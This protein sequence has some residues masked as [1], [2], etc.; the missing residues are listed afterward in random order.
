MQR[1]LAHLLLFP[2]ITT[3]TTELRVPPSA[4]CLASVVQKAQEEG[5]KRVVL[6]RGL[7]RLKETLRLGSGIEVVGEGAVVTGGVPV[8][9]WRQVAGKAWLYMTEAPAGVTGISQLFDSGERVGVARSATMQYTTYVPPGPTF[10]TIQVSAGQ[11]L[12]NYSNPTAMRV[13]KYEYWTASYSQVKS[14]E[15]TT[16]V[17][18]RNASISYYG[19]YASGRRYYLE[20]AFEYLHASSGSFYHDE[21]AG[22]LYYAPADPTRRI[23]TWV[24]NLTELVRVDKQANVTMRGV[25]LQHSRVNWGPCLQSDCTSQSASFS[26]AAAVHVLNSSGVAFVNVTVKHTGDTGVW[27]DV[28][29]RDCSFVAGTVTDVGGSGVRIGP[30]THGVSSQLAQRITVSD[31]TITHGS[32]IYRMGCGVLLQAA[33]DVKVVH[34]E[35]AY[36]RYT[37]IS[38]GWTWNYEETTER[39]N[40][41]A[42]NM[43]HAIGMGDLS[44]LGCVYHLGQDYGTEISG[45]VCTNVTSFDYGGWGYYTDQASRGVLLKGN[46]AYLTKCSGFHQHFG[47]DNVLTNNLFYGVN[48]NTATGGAVCDS[49]LRSSAGDTPGNQDSISNFNFTLNVISTAAGNPPLFMATSKNG[50]ANVTFDSNVYFTP[51]STATFPCK[52][53]AACDCSLQDWRSM[54]QDT[55]SVVGD[56]LMADPGN[57]NFTLLPGSPALALGFQQI[58]TSD[59]GPRGDRGF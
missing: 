4:R 51:G 10:D 34:N 59:V 31:N 30:G 29:S 1:I 7:H 55:H 46:V 15:G 49:A 57:A 42:K 19:G 3:C 9:G 44:D 39:R 50:F 45:N 54:G 5:V 14:A 8:D 36:F 35:V 25:V 48:S 2:I 18:Q 58:D 26:T 24:A 22:L 56:P 40:L 52:G 37:G 41:I 23:D 20:N 43:I 13:V 16:I 27:F 11:L 33:S 17:L 28:L 32:Q 38:V 12:A 21:T 6:E 47:I 53:T